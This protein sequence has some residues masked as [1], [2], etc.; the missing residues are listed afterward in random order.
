MVFNSAVFIFFLVTVLP[1][2]FLLGRFSGDSGR[3]FQNRFLL[4]ASYFFYGYWDWVFLGLIVVSTVTD[5][6]AAI[7]IER[8]EQEKYRRIWLSASMLLNLGLLGAFK[9]YD[10]FIESFIAMVQSIVPGAM[11]GAGERLLLKAVL[12]VGI[13]FYTFQTMSYTIDVY[14]KVIRAE[15]NFLD[16]SLFVTFFPQLVAGPIERAGDLLPQIKEQRKV[17]FQNLKEAAW[18]L[19]L[20]YYLKTVIADN[21]APITDQVYS[22]L[23][24]SGSHGG[25]QVLIANAAFALQIYGDFAG[26]SFIAM[27]TAKLM[28]FELSLNFNAPELSKNPADLWRRWHITLGRWVM[29]YIYVPLGGNRGGRFYHYRNLLITFILMGFWHGA[30]WTFILWGA[31]HG[32]WLLIHASVKEPLRAF[33]EQLPSALRYGSDWLSRFSTFLIFS[34]S[35]PL[36][37]GSDMTQAMALYSSLFTG[38]WDFS[39]SVNQIGSGA[40]L[41]TE[42]MRKIIL[43]L[44]IDASSVVCK[45]TYWI[46]RRPALIRGLL[47]FIM[48][49][50]IIIQGVF[51]KDVIYFAF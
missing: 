9:Y 12:P 19:L 35:A 3:V 40:A 36:F 44:I 17:R 43:L 14:R 5:Y 51:G 25:P 49:M 41:M 48:F 27:G 10:F 33:T 4:A 34:M 6:I 22:P 28:G 45:D 13:S 18:L 2:Y 11:D 24:D 50:Q 23:L 39:V 47:Y 31:F 38:T 32:L 21:L 29:D 8:S 16:F 30:E 20:G 42:L 7:M 26:Y 37:R 46:F 15:K 1:V